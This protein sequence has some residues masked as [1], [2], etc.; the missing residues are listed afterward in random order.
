MV[1]KFKNLSIIYMTFIPN[2]H[3]TNQEPKVEQK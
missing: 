1:I 2:T 3:I